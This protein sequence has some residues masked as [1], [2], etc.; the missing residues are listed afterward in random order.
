MLIRSSLRLYLNGFEHFCVVVVV[1]GVGVGVN[2]R[3]FPIPYGLCG[4]VVLC[5]VKMDPQ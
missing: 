4:S 1:V 2:H 5:E 3:M